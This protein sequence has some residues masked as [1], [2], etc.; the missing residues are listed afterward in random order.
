[1][2]EIVLAPGK[3]VESIEKLGMDVGAIAVVGLFRAPQANR[4]RF[5]FDAKS[6]A[7]SGVTIGLHGC[8]MS[9]A[10]GQPI[11][12]AAEQLRLAGVRCQ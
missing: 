1:M 6:A 11:G 10:E 8:A 4:W 3:Q 9:V 12:A 5:V 2:R 7:A